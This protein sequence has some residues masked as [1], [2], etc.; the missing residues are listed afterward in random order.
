MIKLKV[1]VSKNDH[2]ESG[3]GTYSRDFISASSSQDA[4]A[5]R[6][7]LLLSTSTFSITQPSYNLNTVSWLW[8]MKNKVCCSINYVNNE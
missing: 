5:R 6:E 4:E 1:E 3:Q 8:I 2:K 7:A